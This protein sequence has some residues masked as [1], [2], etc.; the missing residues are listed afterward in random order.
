L[1]K[2]RAAIRDETRLYLRAMEIAAFILGFSV[3]GAAVALATRRYCLQ[4]RV[5]PRT[6]GRY[7]IVCQLLAGA[8]GLFAINA[9]VAAAGLLQ[10]LPPRDAALALVAPGPL[11]NFFAAF[12]ACGVWLFSES[13]YRRSRNPVVGLAGSI[14]ATLAIVIVATE[15]GQWFESW[16]PVSGLLLYQAVIVVAVVLGYR[17]SHGERVAVAG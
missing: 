17:L 5:A 9:V 8:G 15:Y 14:A 1:C 3:V 11:V 7:S 13:W 2:R 12:A 4:G 6:E 16:N 10:D